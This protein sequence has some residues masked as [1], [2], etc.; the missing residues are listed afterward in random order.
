MGE[1]GAHAAEGDDAEGDIGRALVPEGA[2]FDD[3]DGF[4]AGG[5]VVDKGAEL[6]AGGGGG[7]GDVGRPEGDDGASWF[8]LWSHCIALKVE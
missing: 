2:L 8:L 1:V 6:L 7:G 5:E 4:I 3:A